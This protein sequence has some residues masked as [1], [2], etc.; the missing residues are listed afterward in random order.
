M[1]MF[2]TPCHG[3]TVDAPALLNGYRELQGEL[4]ALNE[5]NVELRNKI[6]NANAQLVISATYNSHLQ[7]QLAH[8]ERKKQKSANQNLFGDGLPCIL[9][10][11]E[12]HKQ[13]KEKKE[14]RKPCSE[15]RLCGNRPT[16]ST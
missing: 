9:M 8:K 13:A 3:S 11:S 10:H 4:V 2:K 7:H 15:R 14:K 12:S 6:H 5:A 16:S 1:A